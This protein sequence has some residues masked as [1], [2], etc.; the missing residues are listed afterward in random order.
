MV[1]LIVAVV[2]H[3]NEVLVPIL[4]AAALVI[5]VATRTHG[6][7]PKWVATNNITKVIPRLFPALIVFCL[8]FYPPWRKRI[9]GEK[10]PVENPR[11]VPPPYVLLLRTQYPMSRQNEIRKKQREIRRREKRLAKTGARVIW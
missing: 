7:L 6:L 3:V 8:P 11:L 4:D 5:V 10:P 1:P 9:I 2:D